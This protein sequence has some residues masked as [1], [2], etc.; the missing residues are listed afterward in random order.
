MK[1]KDKN[2][3]IIKGLFERKSNIE[4]D[5]LVEKIY[6]ENYAYF[7]R[8]AYSVLENHSDAEEAVSESFLK[9][10]KNKEKF[11]KMKCPEIIAYS[12]SI[13]RNL[14]I[15]M[16]KSQNKILF[17][18]FSEELID[19]VSFSESVYMTLFNNL[20]NQELYEL[21]SILNE[22]EYEIFEL[23]AID[24]LTFK[25]IA[26]R[27]DIDISEEATKKKFQRLVKK[28]REEKERRSK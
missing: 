22:T 13:V 12:V 8:T 25:E 26:K 19:S 14:S 27:I 6:I 24:R 16:K 20:E 4:F 21:L 2:K 17:S 5:E 3:K 9:F 28:L 15:D 18:E 1:T 23:R 7:Y 11:S 10:Y